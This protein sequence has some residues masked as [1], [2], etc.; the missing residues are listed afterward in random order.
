MEIIL[1]ERQI[2][3]CATP[4]PILKTK[5]IRMDKK[6]YPII[7]GSRIHSVTFKDQV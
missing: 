7:K 2:T 4:G 1:S 3:S 5:K 6:G